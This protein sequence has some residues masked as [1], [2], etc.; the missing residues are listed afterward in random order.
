MKNKI[1]FE[2][3]KDMKGLILNM[4]MFNENRAGSGSGYSLPAVSTN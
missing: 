2:R 1:T 3:K 4:I